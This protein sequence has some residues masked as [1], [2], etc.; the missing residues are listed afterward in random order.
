MPS[1]SVSGAPQ[2]LP[3]YGRNRGTDP[4]GHTDRLEEALQHLVCQGKLPLAQAQH[5]ITTD[6]VAA[7]RTYVGP[8]A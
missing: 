5:A 6:W 3:T 1:R 7:Y 8:I 2:R 4:R